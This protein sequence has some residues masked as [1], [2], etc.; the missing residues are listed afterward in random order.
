[1]AVKL[2]KER[3]GHFGSG[4]ALAGKTKGAAGGVVRTMIAVDTV[5]NA[6]QV[7]TLGQ[8]VASSTSP[9]QD[10]I[11]KM[12][13][14]AVPLLL[15][16]CQG[17]TKKSNVL[18]VPGV[19]IR[20]CCS[21]ADTSDLVAIVP[22]SHDASI[23]RRVVSAPPVRL[24]VIVHQNFLSHVTVGLVDNGRV[25]HVFGH[26][27]APVI[28][29]FAEWEGRVQKHVANDQ[30]R[31]LHHGAST[32]LGR[33]GV[34]LVAT[35][36]GLFRLVLRISSRFLVRPENF[37]QIRHAWSVRRD[38]TKAPTNDSAHGNATKSRGNGC[39]EKNET[40]HPMTEEI[41]RDAIHQEEGTAIMEVK[42]G[43]N[44]KSNRGNVAHIVQVLKVCL[45]RCRLVF[46]HGV[47]EGVARLGMLDEQ[48]TD[49][50]TDGAKV[51]GGD[52]RRHDGDGHQQ[53]CAKHL[54][55]EDPCVLATEIVL[56]FHHL[57]VFNHLKANKHR[58]RPQLLQRSDRRPSHHGNLDG[59]GRTNN[60]KCR[61]GPMELGG[62]PAQQDQNT[63]VDANDVDHKDVPAPNS[64]HVKV[65]QT[66]EDA[67]DQPAAGIVLSAAQGP[68]P[69]I[70]RHGHGRHGD[71]FVVVPAP[72]GTHEMG[73]YDGHDGRRREEGFDRRRRQGGRSAGWGDVDQAQVGTKH[74]RDDPNEQFGNR[75]DQTAVQNVDDGDGGQDGTKDFRIG[76]LGLGGS[77]SLGSLLLLL[78]L[79]LDSHARLVGH[80][81]GKY[82][83]DGTEPGGDEAANVVQRH[84]IAQHLLDED[85]AHL[86]AGVDG[87][88]DGP[89]E[90]IPD[91][92]I[93]PRLEGVPPVLVQVLRRAVVE[94]RVEL[95][96][97]HPV[98]LDGVEADVVGLVDD[99]EEDLEG[100][101]GPKAGV[102]EAEGGGT[103]EGLEESIRR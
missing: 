78:G 34:V 56:P 100:D 16:A 64:D 79:L 59:K 29:F 37:E 91:L 89:A 39:R 26:F 67:P 98:L 95:V 99:F 21:V 5:G 63:G 7:R 85:A 88:A 71:G 49:T 77:L 101:D 27:S 46:R 54:D 22:P 28:K 72:D 97:D 75:H 70:E 58:H 33:R 60:V 14:N 62:V 30:T 84:A 82:S 36:F 52:Q 6:C 87:R 48:S 92:V 4:H 74:G 66:G 96:D 25:R 57:T 69:Q 61:V 18:V 68:H 15:G 50:C 81:S 102:D 10:V 44:D 3:S 24:A 76:W 11:G 9:D 73:R 80:E 13:S 20:N 43:D 90:G 12:T 94:P 53:S 40:N 31:N 2:V 41:C 86:H 35:L 45:G 8:V 51:T 55:T 38:A 32:V 42:E 93:E 47:H 65:G 1:M 103:E 83:S 17:L 19:A 23:L